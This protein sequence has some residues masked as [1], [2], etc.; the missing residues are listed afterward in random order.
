MYNSQKTPLDLVD[1]VVNVQGRGR[2]QYSLQNL[3]SFDD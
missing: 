2:S 1:K 3:I